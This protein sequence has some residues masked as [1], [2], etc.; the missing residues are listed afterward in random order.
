MH[1]LYT[2]RY[3]TIGILFTRFGWFQIKLQFFI[4]QSKKKKTRPINSIP[5]HKIKLIPYNAFFIDF[6]LN[7]VLIFLR[8]IP[9]N[10]N[11]FSCFI[12]FFFNF[13]TLLS[14]WDHWNWNC[15]LMMMFVKKMTIA[16]ELLSFRAQWNHMKM[17]M[18]V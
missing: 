8:Q 3:R 11:Y 6:F 18:D 10:F 9:L 16:C 7:I 4:V 13:F 12:F 2:N 15:T 14:T 17:Y 1:S 5:Q